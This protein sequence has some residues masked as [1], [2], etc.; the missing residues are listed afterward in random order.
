[1]EFKPGTKLMSRD[2]YNSMKVDQACAM[3][4][5]LSRSSRRPLEV[6]APVYLRGASPRSR[7]S[8]FPLQGRPARGSVKIYAVGGARCANEILGLPVSDR[9]YVVVGA[10]PERHGA[11]GIQ[12]GGQGTS[13]SS[14]TLKPTRSTRSRAPS[15]KGRARPTKGFQI[16]RGRPT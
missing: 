6:V 7:Y 3:A 15:A 2:N 13:P 5:F 1:M 12:A 14:C 10:T 11:P 9:D 8:W 16:P 4:R